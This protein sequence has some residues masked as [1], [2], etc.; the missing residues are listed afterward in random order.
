MN[1]A[2][3]SNLVSNW[4]RANLAIHSEKIKSFLDLNFNRLSI[5]TR[6]NMDH[7]IN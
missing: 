3:V 5:W 1:T 4:T 6:V 7:E 2:H